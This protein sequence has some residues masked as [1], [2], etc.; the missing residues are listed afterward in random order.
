[1]IN[2][3]AQGRE[4]E[5]ARQV[6]EENKQ[7]LANDEIS[8]LREIVRCA[9]GVVRTSHPVRIYD[10][11]VWDWWVAL[12]NALDAEIKHPIDFEPKPGVNYIEEYTP[13]HIS[14]NSHGYWEEEVWDGPDL[15][16]EG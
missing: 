3:W 9:K 6:E 13:R 11:V 12:K 10:G 16:G 7:L 4:R 14:M 8:S 1:M 5:E 2:P 15:G